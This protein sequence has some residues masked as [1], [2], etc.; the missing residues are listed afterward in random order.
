MDDKL[1]DKQRKLIT[2]NYELL[3][4]FVGHTIEDSIIPQYLE[5]EFISYMHLKFCFSA[6]KYNIDTGFKFSTYA[7]YGFQLG[8]RDLVEKK[9]KFEKIQYID[10]INENDLRACKLSNKKV[11]VKLGVIDNFIDNASLTLRERSMIEDHYYDKVSFSKLGKKYSV[12]KEGSR[13]IVNRALKKLKQTA[14]MMDLD[15]DDFYA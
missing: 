14:I 10:I 1:T 15:M 5:D 2:D 4:K 13:L 9:K 6:L 7:H 8:I 12:S 3:N 11:S